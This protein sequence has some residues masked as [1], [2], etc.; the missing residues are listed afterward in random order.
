MTS[1]TDAGREKRR[2]DI[3]ELGLAKLTK[4]QL[5]DLLLITRADLNKEKA[6][7]TAAERDTE[8]AA[9]AL[10]RVEH[11]LKCLANAITV[12]NA[13]QAKGLDQ[14]FAAMVINAVNHT[15]KEE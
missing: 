2:R 7:R 12:G 5:L 10:V 1:L 4:A 15:R 11:R 13:A 3:E 8:Q 9:S 6:L 14:L